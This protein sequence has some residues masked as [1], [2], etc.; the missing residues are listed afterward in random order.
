MPPL[1]D[2]A[3]VKMCDIILGNTWLM[4][5]VRHMISVNE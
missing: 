3:V 4:C 5:V 2:E 1:Q